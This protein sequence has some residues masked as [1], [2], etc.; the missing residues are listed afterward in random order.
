ML[1]V[2]GIFLLALTCSFI[3]LPSNN[4]FGDPGGFAGSGSYSSGGGGSSHSSGGSGHSS[5]SNDY[6]DDDDDYLPYGN[7]YDDTDGGNLT[8]GM[9]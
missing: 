5:S 3:S 1:V 6:D 9:D 2:I 4:A 8:S 7:I